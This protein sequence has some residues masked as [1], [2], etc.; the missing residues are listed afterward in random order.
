MRISKAYIEL[1][2]L[3]LLPDL[4]VA[5]VLMNPLLE[6][7]FK[8]YHSIL[9]EKYQHL[10]FLVGVNFYVVKWRFGYYRFFLGIWWSIL[11]TLFH[12]VSTLINIQLKCYL[13]IILKIRMTSGSLRLKLRKFWDLGCVIIRGSRFQDGRRS[14]CHFINFIYLFY[15]YK[16]IHTCMYIKINT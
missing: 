7:Y 14:A 13:G 12:F 9:L 10:Y 16:C 6:L 2:F 5:W 8:V 1:L 4:E 15:S 11:S 3:Y